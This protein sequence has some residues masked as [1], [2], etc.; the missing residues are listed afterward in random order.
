MNRD[1]FGSSTGRAARRSRSPA[2]AGVQQPPDLDGIDRSR[3]RR[4]S[5]ASDIPGRSMTISQNVRPSPP[6]GSSD[7]TAELAGDHGIAVDPA[8]DQGMERLVTAALVHP[9]ERHEDPPALRHP[10]GTQQADRRDHR[11]VRALHVGRASRRS[12][13]SSRRSGGVCSTSIASR[14][15]CHW[16]VGPSPAP[17]S[18]MTLGLFGN[19][20]SSRTRGTRVR[21]LGRQAIGHLGLVPG[22]APDPQQVEGQV[23][24][25]GSGSICRQASRRSARL[26]RAPRPCARVSPVP[27]PV[28]AGRARQASS[29]P[30]GRAAGRCAAAASAVP[31]PDR[32][33]ETVCELAA[34]LRK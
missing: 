13:R 34:F 3:A 5:R 17:S 7:A 21:Q 29:G 12:S 16:M 8:R 1:G 32:V 27:T 31:R 20:R 18:A 23:A 22:R 28:R 33:D 25:I 14:C 11:R 26:N 15:P 19:S 4:R 30:R 2:S 6:I 9:V 10:V 24:A